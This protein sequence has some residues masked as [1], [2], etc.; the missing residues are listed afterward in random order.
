M[1]KPKAIICPSV[2]ACDLSNLTNECKRVLDAK[3]DWLHLDV[4]DGH[5]VPNLTFG[6]PV[7]SHLRKNCPNAFLDCHLMVS[8]PAQWIPEYKKAGADGFTFHIESN[9]PEGGVLNLIETIK[10]A[11]MK[12]GVSVK[13]NT[14]IED[15]LHVCDKVDM[16]LI[17]TVEPGFGGQKFMPDMMPKVQKIRELYPNMNIQVD[18]GLSPSTIDVAAR[19]GANVIVAGSSVYGSKDPA[20]AIL[21]MRESVDKAMS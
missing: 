16:V 5:F 13:P 20:A 6:H 9:M 17:M 19:A 10:E 1:T 18:G 4:M 12:C 21:A 14:P 15:I 3:A 7:V 2:L 8:N 11:G